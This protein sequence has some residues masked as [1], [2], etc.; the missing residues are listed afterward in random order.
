M[1]EIKKYVE[2]EERTRLDLD[3][4]AQKAFEGVEIVENTTWS[5]PDWSIINRHDG[6]IVMYYNLVVRSVDFDGT[7]F[8]VAGINNVITHPDFQGQGYASRTLKH[9]RDFIFNTLKAD[10]GLLLCGDELV[11]FYKKLGWHKFSGDLIVEQPQVG[12]I[13]WSSNT[14]LMSKRPIPCSK[15]INLNGLPW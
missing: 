12:P 5:T 6:K 7:P 13:H 2:L 10:F 11:G 4:M 1:I 9:T 14:M 15:E 3:Q 8:S